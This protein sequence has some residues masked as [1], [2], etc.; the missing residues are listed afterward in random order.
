MDIAKLWENYF[1]KKRYILYYIDRIVPFSNVVCV[2]MAECDTDSL[3]KLAD[4]RLSKYLLMRKGDN[5]WILFYY[6][7]DNKIYGYSFLHVPT[8][9][10]WNDSIPTMLNEAR[11]SSS[12]VYPEYRGKG[13]RGE[14]ANCQIK[15]ANNNGLILWSVIEASNKASLKAS[16][17]IGSIRKN[18]YLFKIVGRNII[19]ITTKPF[20]ASILLRKKRAK[21]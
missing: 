12:Y 13:I 16:L 19:S 17:K 18:N 20:R 7:L 2:S 3:L 21:R 6:K 11:T 1:F 8:K 14:I 10:E 4:S 15:Y 5:A 9:E